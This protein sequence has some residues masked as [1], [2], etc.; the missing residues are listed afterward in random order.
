VTDSEYRRTRYTYDP[1]R[2]AVWQHITRDLARWIPPTADVLELG[3]GYCDFSNNVVARSRTALDIDPSFK[4]HAAAGVHC[5]VGD[6]ADLTGLDAAS[7]DVVFASNLLEHLDRPALRELLAHLRRVLRPGGRFIAIQ[8]NFRLQPKQYF[9][10]YT[11]VT[12]FTDRSLPDFLESE[13]LAVE[14]V[15]AR[16]LPLTMKSRLAGAHRLV[17]LYLKSPVKPLA[18]QM[19]VV[20]SSPPS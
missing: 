7:F 16:Y 14:H 19:L 11:H 20:A 1:R 15:A 3:A 4:Q 17:P 5:V 2:V 13:G 10:D 18:G 6:C 9:D 12:V 8:P